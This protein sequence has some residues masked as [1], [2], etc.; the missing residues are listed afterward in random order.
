MKLSLQRASESPSAAEP[1]AND[2]ADNDEF[3]CNP[4]E[5]RTVWICLRHKEPQFVFVGGVSFCQSSRV[6]RRE[7]I[8]RKFTFGLNISNFR[9]K[10]GV[11]SLQLCFSK[12][13]GDSRTH[14]ICPG[15]VTGAQRG[16]LGALSLPCSLGA[17]TR[18]TGDAPGAS[19]F[20]LLSSLPSTAHPCPA[21]LPGHGRGFC[22]SLF[23]TDE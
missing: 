7:T 14:R 16:M 6:K 15:G 5:E 12:A 20:K 11:L 22:L 17:A 8:R 18:G 2:A 10:M 13:H 19:A 3:L 4:R 21:H 9:Q 1:T 23:T